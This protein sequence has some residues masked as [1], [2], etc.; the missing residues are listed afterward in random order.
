MNFPF[1]CTNRRGNTLAVRGRTR[2]APECD[3]RGQSEERGIV[4]GQL[5]VSS[6]DATESF[7][8]VE[9]LFEPVFGQIKQARG[10][11]QLLLRGLDQVW[12]EWTM[13][14]TAHNLL[15]LAKARH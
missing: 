1:Q 15:K 3:D 9:G 7:E 13:I 6:S 14:C 12:G 5:V 10:F 4:A 11:R 2:L 8:V